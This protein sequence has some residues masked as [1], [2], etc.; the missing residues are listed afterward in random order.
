MNCI[1]FFGLTIFSAITAFSNNK[2]MTGLSYYNSN[3]VVPKRV[4]TCIGGRRWCDFDETKRPRPSTFYLNVGKALEVLRRE[5]PMVFVVSNLD[6]S[7]FAD[8]IKV[9]NENQ[10]NILMSKYLYTVAVKSMQMT[11]SFSSIYPSM[12]IN[13]IEYVEDCSTIQCLVHIV[14]PETLRINDQAVW[15][16][17]FYF[18]L[19]SEGLISSHTIDRKISN[20]TP[21][22]HQEHPHP[23]HPN[24]P[25][26]RNISSH[27]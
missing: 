7:I 8:S 25:W 18:G 17:M 24:V 15:E 11:A 22:S 6:F 3:K 9:T 26:L 10:S 1:F 14:L 19:D 2:I 13:K 4:I 23:H 21:T 27:I 20:M 12:N 5:L 16:G